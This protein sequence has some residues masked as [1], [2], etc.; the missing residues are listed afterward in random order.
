MT[1][2]PPATAGNQQ[3]D[4]NTEYELI[5]I[6]YKTAEYWCR[7]RAI[8]ANI[9]QAQWSRAPIALKTKFPLQT[10]FKG[11]AQ[12]VVPFYDPYYNP[13]S[14]W[15]PTFV[16]P[17]RPKSD[18]NKP[19]YMQLIDAEPYL[20]HLAPADDKEIVLLTEGHGKMLTAYAWAP[21]EYGV[22]GYPGNMAWDRVNFS[23][24]NGKTVVHIPDTE[25]Y[26]KGTESAQ[27]KIK[28]GIEEAGG[29]YIPARPPSLPNRKKTGLDDWLRS[30]AADFRTEY[31]VALATSA[32]DAL[33]IR[34][35]LRLISANDFLYSEELNQPP[36]WGSKDRVA[37]APGESLMLVSATGVGKSTLSQNIML[38]RLGL[39]ATVL[40]MPVRDTG[41]KVLYLA[42]DRPKQIAR[43]MRR[44]LQ[45]DY[46]D[47]LQER[48][49]VHKGP[50]PVDI[51]RNKDWLAD[52]AEENDVKTIIVDS[53]KDAVRRPSDEEL[54][55]GYNLARQEC[56][57]RDIEWLEDHHTRKTEDG[58]KSIDDVYGSSQ[59]TNGAGSVIA[60]RGVAGDS[61]I[62]LVQL[63]FPEG[64][65]LP[66]KVR[67]DHLLGTVDIHNRE[68]TL[69]DMLATGNPFTANYAAEILYKSQN[70][71]ESQVES[72][73]T[74]I[75]RKVSSYEAVI[76]QDKEAGTGRIL[77]RGT[78]ADDL[79]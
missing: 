78:G 66:M 49:I 46:K 75:K 76:H 37:W 10:F 23:W 5:G 13:E 42:M 21:A 67:I 65:I 55:N 63:K 6:V 15:Q 45:P 14:P 27:V 36:L 3:H 69:D 47:V 25:P 7:D 70:P 51:C 34:S 2:M 39:I 19:R 26:N 4:Q 32:I 17:D 61:V 16:Y 64:E 58:L 71:T 43:A 33:E 56:L 31:L 77:Y 59:L 53:L 28:A 50:L 74:R 29:R 54:A 11:E 35:T 9:I 73:R 52:L 18:K 41:G 57:A 60:L 72:A 22:V 8:P 30:I 48:L 40:E 38:G 62:D 79:L 1:L 24:A 12:L 20:N 44:L 68:L